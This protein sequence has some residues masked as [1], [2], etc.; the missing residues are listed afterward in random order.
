MRSTL[1]KT[2]EYPYLTI[3]NGNTRGDLLGLARAANLYYPDTIKNPISEKG[4]AIY[5]LDQMAPLNG[6]DHGDAHSAIGD[7]MA[8]VGIAKLIANNAP[9]NEWNLI[10]KNKTYYYQDQNL[11]IRINTKN[12][13]SK[14]LLENLGH[15]IKIALDLKISKKIIEKT[16]PKLIFVGRFQYLKKGKIKNKLHK[17][18]KLM[19]DGAHATADAKNLAD[20]LKT[21]KLPKYGIWAMTKNKEP[22][23]FIKEFR[24]I[25]HKLVTH[26]FCYLFT[27]RSK[28]LIKRVF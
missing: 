20:Y 19:I 26:V 15:A 17:N 4:N 22:D 16:I 3:T 5:K 13:H 27:H 1:F 14:G 18:E 8:T 12:I 24:N 9:K 7:V 6:I 10:K 23:L 2:L 28:R 11:K 25:F 21:I